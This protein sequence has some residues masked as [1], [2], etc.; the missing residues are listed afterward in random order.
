MSQVH[1][2]DLD[3]RIT[4]FWTAVLNEPER[5]A[6]AILSIPVNVE[7]WKKQR[8]VYQNADTSN[9]FA[10]GFSTFYL[11]RCNRSGALSGAA[12]IGGYDQ[13]GKWR[14]NARFNK[15]RLAERVFAVAKRREQIHIT[16]MDARMFLATHL[17]RGHR[18]ERVFVY[19]DPPYYSNGHRLYLNSYR[20]QDHRI[21]SRYIKRQRTLK[22]VISYDDTRF[23]RDLYSNCTIT[24]LSV[25]YSFQRTQRAREL[26]IV[27]SRM[28]LP[29]AST[30]V[31]DPN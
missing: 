23:I 4:A 25:R 8:C 11:N 13:K 12:P 10:L 17:P 9:L 7:E 3:H 1:L 14:I 30:E 31:T 22:W 24:H 28:Q 16:T 19:L 15:E 26:L 21:L 27:P 5:F 18:R 20:D 29:P 2:N 6:D